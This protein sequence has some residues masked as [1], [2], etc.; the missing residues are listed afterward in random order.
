M[1]EQNDG[2]AAFPGVSGDGRDENQGMSL[3]DFF[4]AEASKGAADA[5]CDEMD[6]SDPEH[7]VDL[8]DVQQ[9]AD[10]HATAA[11]LY[12]DAMLKARKG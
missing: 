5:L 7:P 11:Y 6:P 2:G 10:R 4:A 12:A 9:H 1:S 8:A 3:R